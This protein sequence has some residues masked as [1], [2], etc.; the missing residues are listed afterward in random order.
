VGT[1]AIQQSFSEDVLAAGMLV[2][3]VLMLA[4]DYT[5]Y[6]CCIFCSLN[7]YEK[8]KKIRTHRSRKYRKIM[9]VK[10]QHKLLTHL[11]KEK[12]NVCKCKTGKV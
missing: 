2:A 6:K 8:I 9:H 10:P 11:Q 1:F 4:D 5:P 12:T 3:D 7:S